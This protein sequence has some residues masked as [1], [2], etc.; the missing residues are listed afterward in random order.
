MNTRGVAMAASGDLV[1]GIESAR[2]A[3]ALGLE[4]G[5]ID[6]ARAYINVASLEGEYGDVESSRNH[7]R[8]GFELAE[9]LGNRSFADWL[10]CEVVLDDLESGAWDA[11]MAQGPSLLASRRERGVS[12]YMDVALQTAVVVVTAAREGRFLDDLSDAALGAARAIGEPQSLLPTLAALADAN[13]I[14]GRDAEAEALLDELVGSVTRVASYGY[15][16]VWVVTAALAWRTLRDS[17]VPAEL[18]HGQRTRWA[19][20]ARHLAEGEAVE[21]A[22]ALAAIGATVTEA[23]VREHAAALLAASDAGAA[24]AQLARALDAWAGMGADDGSAGSIRSAP[25]SGRLPRSVATPPRPTGSRATRSRPTRARVAHRDRAPAGRS[26][27]S[28]LA[29]PSR[30][31]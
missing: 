9:R 8:E 24:G 17:P 10:A 19:D 21:A 6:T 12:H 18:L 15:P 5:A 1:G 20:V 14:V 29:G 7:H 26:R 16:R 2:D 3:L 13:R 25:G 27:R 22:D 30:R 4:I 31:P 28:Q 11:V 23:G